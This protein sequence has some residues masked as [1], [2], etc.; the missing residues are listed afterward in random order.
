MRNFK[1]PV[2]WQ[3]SGVVNIEAESLDEA[4]RIFDE[5]SD[6]IKLPSQNEYI[7]DSFQRDDVETCKLYNE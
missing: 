5:N 4:L 6:N 7:D 3:V 1:I 2:T